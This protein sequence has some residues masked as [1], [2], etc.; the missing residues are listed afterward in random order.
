MNRWQTNMIF[1]LFISNIYLCKYCR[2]LPVRHLI[3][4]IHIY[5][6]HLA[7]VNEEKCVKKCKFSSV[8]RKTD[9]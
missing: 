6:G 5:R 1:A 8:S 3:I 9:I 2:Y 7:F 4:F